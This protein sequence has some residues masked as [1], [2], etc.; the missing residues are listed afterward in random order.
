MSLISANIRLLPALTLSIAAALQTCVVATAEEAK[1]D[2]KAQAK[3]T[4]EE[5]VQAIFRQH[6]FTCHGPDTAKSDLRLD[7]YAAMMRGGASGAVIEPGDAD[8]SRLWKL[9]SHEETP[10]MP[11][12]QDKLPE[13]TLAT[14]KQWIT[15]GALEKAGSTAK[16]KA[17]PKIEMKASAGAGK[18]EGPPPMP[19]G[20]T[21]QPS[22]YT[23]RPAAVTALAASPWAPLVAVAGQKQIVLYNTDNAQLLGVLAFPEGTPQV[24]R[25]S[26]SGTVLLAGGGRDGQSGRVVL[27]DVKSGQ[28]ITEIGDELDTVLA[29]DIND[30]HTQV[31]LGG[32]RRVVKIYNVADGALVHEIRKHTEWITAIEYSPDGVLLAT[33][34]RNGGMFVWEAETA[35]EYQNLKG[36]T[37]CIGAV[38]WRIDGNILAST[39]E[40]GTLKLWEME[41]GQVVKNWAAHGGG[42]LSVHFA[43]D[44]RLVSCGRDKT[45]KI[46]DQNGAQQ[47]ALEA[48][49]DI[50]LRSV[51]AHDGGR[52]VAGD[53]TGEI[54][55]WNASDGA[56]VT[57]L[58]SNP[59]TLAMLAE[60]EAARAAAAKVAAEAA[61]AELAAAQKAADEKT[62]AAAALAERLKALQAEIEKVATD[63]AAADKTL[64]DKAAAAKAAGDAAA[65]AAS[66]AA[67]AAEEKAAY[68]KTQ[69]A[70]AS[71]SN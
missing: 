21:R 19:E 67:R 68:D 51:F 64:A 49:G 6:C 20:L 31:A 66:A 38:S 17:K 16:I 71:A 58:A 11:P 63:K 46:W 56:L 5:H 1:P 3:V 33:A 54:R 29:A 60:A 47:R 41:Q 15:L 53:W 2:D 45:T 42:S 55:V 10:E 34:D 35:R 36:H 65:A 4:Y 69:T 44:G 27:F 24:L 14:L 43:M 26:R 61:T 32:P 7:N 50:A 23:V 62:A 28:R 59:P 9:V 30:D 40:D 22:V 12:K 25:F 39:S 13:A 18:P 48:F 37:A 57:K 70:Q 52:V 8:S